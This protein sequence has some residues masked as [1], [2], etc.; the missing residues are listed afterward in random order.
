MRISCYE[1][2]VNVVVLI[3]VPVIDEKNPDEPVTDEVVNVFA[4]DAPPFTTNAPEEIDV[5]SL[6]PSISTRGLPEILL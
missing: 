6:V 3:I 2:V 5:L 1:D 4:T